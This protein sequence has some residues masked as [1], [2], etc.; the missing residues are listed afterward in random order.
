MSNKTIIY[1][2]DLFAGAT[3]AASTEVAGYE[4]EFL[5]DYTP[6]SLWQSSADPSTI[7]IDLTTVGQL[8]SAIWVGGSNMVAADTTY[9]YGM[10]TAAAAVDRVVNLDKQANSFYELIDNYRYGKLTL[11]K[12]AGNGEA[13]KVYLAEHKF[14]FPKDINRGFSAGS[15][16]VWVEN[17]G[18]YGQ[19]NRTLQYS[20]YI[21]SFDIN[22]MN[23]TQ[24]EILDETIREQ[25]FVIFWD[26]EKQKA[27]YGV[28]E[29]GVPKFI[30]SNLSGGIWEISG[31]FTEAL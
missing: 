5:Q 21:T 23:D 7:S 3:I 27:F 25:D 26:G 20:K 22:G 11:N 2:G 24:K 28:I 18:R 31:T 6:T 14:E 13:G 15:Q 29:L 19:V 1:Y 16:S 10:G 17:S 8:Q 30:T 12:A 4:K 9:T